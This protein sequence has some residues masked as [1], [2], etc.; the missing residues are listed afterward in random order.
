MKVVPVD[1]DG[2]PTAY[3]FS[4]EQKKQLTDRV[5]VSNS[6]KRPMGRKKIAAMICAGVLLFELLL[7]AG[8]PKPERW[9]VMER[10]G[11]AITWEAMRGNYSSQRIVQLEQQYDRNNL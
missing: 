9:D 1:K 3:V 8:S 11:T 10:N 4:E 5:P 7:Y 2:H 6:A